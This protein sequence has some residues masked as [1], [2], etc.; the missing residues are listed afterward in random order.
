M[1]FSGNLLVS[2]IL[3][4]GADFTVPLGIYDRVPAPTSLS[5]GGVPSEALTCP[6]QT[7]PGTATTAA[8]LTKWPRWETQ[9]I[10]H[11]VAAKPHRDRQYLKQ[12][13][14]RFW[15]PVPGYTQLGFESHEHGP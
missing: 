3:L 15:Q 12:P 2:I 14:S 7:R 13:D 5:S 4:Y 1:Q 8:T 9:D 10:Q 11:R 6:P